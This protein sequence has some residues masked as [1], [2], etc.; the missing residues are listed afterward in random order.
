MTMVKMS[1]SKCTNLLRTRKSPYHIPRP[2]YETSKHHQGPFDLMIMPGVCFDR[3]GGRA[4]YGMGHYDRFLTDHLAVFGRLPFLLAICH[5]EQLLQDEQLL[6][7]SHDIRVDM[8]L[9]STAL[10]KI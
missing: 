3:L 6:L 2:P 9:T 5:D 4:G 10:L 7:E 1:Q 8:I